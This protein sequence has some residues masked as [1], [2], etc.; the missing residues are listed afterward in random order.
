[1]KNHQTTVL[2][3]SIPML[4]LGASPQKTLGAFEVFILLPGRRFDHLRAG[5]PCRRAAA[6]LTTDA[7]AAASFHALNEAGTS[8]QTA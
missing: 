1:M 8:I 2:A 7:T 4:T 3:A 6:Q 5:F